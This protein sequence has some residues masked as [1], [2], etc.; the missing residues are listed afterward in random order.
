MGRALAVAAL[1][2]TLA[3]LAS[4]CGGGGSSTTTTTPGTTPVVEWA[5]D[6]CTAITS[7]K[8]D[9][10]SVG[11]DLASNP[12]KDGLQQA[13]D[14]V[15]SANQ[16]LTDALKGLGTPDTPSGDEVKQSVDDLSSTLDTQLTKIE[17][18]VRNV[19]GLSGI[20]GAAA[21]VS[22]SLTAMQAALT[23]T[24]KAID[25]A[26]VQGELKAGFDQADSCSSLRSSG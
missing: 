14:S 23:N 13:A 21:T 3:V 1:T 20:V 10:T 9:L 7:W 17:D 26:D 8:D 4:G 11:K 12:T 25:D 6:F 18:T 24:L 16:T 15:K 22:T 5:G 2:G 19:S